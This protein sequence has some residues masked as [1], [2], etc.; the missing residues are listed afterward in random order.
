MVTLPIPLPNGFT[1]QVEPGDSVKTGDVL[2][3][4]DPQ[5]EISISIPEILKIPIKKSAKA[6]RRN[7]GDRVEKGGILA[8]KK[9][10]FGMSEDVI[11]SQVDGTVLRYERDTGQI[12]L[13]PATGDKEDEQVIAETVCSP[14]DGVVELCDN[15]KILLRTE[16]DII[17]GTGGIGADFTGLVYNI[18]QSQEDPEG[19][20]QLHFLD[21]SVIG[22]IVIGG[23]FD[24]DVLLKA[25][26]MG[27]GGVI[28]YAVKEEDLAHVAER[29][30]TTPVITVDKEGYLR[31]LQWSG[32]KI[33]MQGDSKT[34][35]L[36]HL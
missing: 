20:V 28:G 18:T 35:L 31:L 25:I 23:A 12:I 7:P 13:V 5:K 9:T 10:K 36:L 1:V 27:V 21:S 34:V 32:K 3:K 8:S 29:H 4:K 14:I 33:Y 17:A 22:T 26:G 6:L 2:A 11:V 15:D 19:K 24:R 30:L 16:K